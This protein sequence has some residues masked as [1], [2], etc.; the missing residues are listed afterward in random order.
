[1]SESLKKDFWD[2]AAL[3]SYFTTEEMLTFFMEKYPAANAWHSEKSLSFFKDSDKDPD[4]KDLSGNT[5]Q[6]VKDLILR[7]LRM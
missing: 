6:G 4:P 5:W 3:L 7:S 2:Y 1:L